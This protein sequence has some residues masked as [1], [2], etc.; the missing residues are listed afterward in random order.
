M[1]TLFIIFLLRSLK[2]DY[3][4]EALRRVTSENSDLAVCVCQSVKSKGWHH[5]LPGGRGSVATTLRV[6]HRITPAP[7]KVYPQKDAR[8][9]DVTYDFHPLSLCQLKECFLAAVNLIR[10]F[11][12][13]IHPVDVQSKSQSPGHGPDPQSFVKTLGGSPSANL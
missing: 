3:V 13:S 8:A 2:R 6:E 11:T 4:W 1:S 7:I 5:F 9:C 10:Q 12:V